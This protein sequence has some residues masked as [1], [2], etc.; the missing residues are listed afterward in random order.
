MTCRLKICPVAGPCGFTACPRNN[1]LCTTPSNRR[2][3]Y[4]VSLCRWQR[5]AGSTVKPAS[6]SQTTRSASYPLAIEP[7]RLPSP[8]SL[9]GPADIHRTTSSMPT[10]RWRASVQ[11]AERPSSSDAI[12]PQAEKKLPVSLHFIAGGHGEWSETT[13]SIPP[14]QSARQSASRFVDSRIGGAHLNSVA[15]GNLLCLESKVM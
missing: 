13:K 7:F 9:A 12:P 3:A 2:P 1:V 8:A 6:G 10:E 5:R 14:P 15:V 11:T 4:G